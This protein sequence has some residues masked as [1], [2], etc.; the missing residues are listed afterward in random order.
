MLCAIPFSPS[1]CFKF[2]LILFS[3]ILRNE[4]HISPKAWCFYYHLSFLLNASLFPPRHLFCVF[5]IHTRRVIWM[6]M[7]RPF[8]TY[9]R[10]LNLWNLCIFPGFDV[11]W[12][13]RTLSLFQ[14]YACTPL[15]FAVKGITPPPLIPQFQSQWVTPLLCPVLDY[16]GYYV[17]IYTFLD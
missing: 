2:S 10:C 4:Y 9:I 3:K 14:K 11:I 7:T 1:Q 5:E 6:R 16:P 8:L 12:I 17:Q 13:T 15:I